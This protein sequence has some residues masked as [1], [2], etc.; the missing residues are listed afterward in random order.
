M[1]MHACR[2]LAAQSSSGKHLAEGFGL[3][4]VGREPGLPEGQSSQAVLNQLAA[5]PQAL[6][7]HLHHVIK[8]DIANA[9]ERAHQNLCYGMV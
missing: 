2:R 8:L 6:R 1:L 7:M 3:V 4:G 9:L 5:R